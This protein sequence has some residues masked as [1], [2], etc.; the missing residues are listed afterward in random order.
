MTT[1]HVHDLDMPT[2]FLVV[3]P[4]TS[5]GTPWGIAQ[6][7]PEASNVTQFYSRVMKEPPDN[8]MV[9]SAITAN[10]R[11]LVERLGGH[12]GETNEGWF[13]YDRWPY[14]QHV[15]HEGMKHGWYRK[16]E[17]PQ[18]EKRTFYV[19]GATSFELIEPILEYSKQLVATH[20]DGT[21]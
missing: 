5:K 15:T 8:E 20:F 19:G 12:L 16:L 17:A 14:F 11:A 10:V 3:Q 6:Q 7:F 18:G 1:Y 21:A 9:E 2:P 13:T 4:L